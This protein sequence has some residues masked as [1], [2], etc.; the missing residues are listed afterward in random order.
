MGNSTQRRGLPGC[1]VT[2]FLLAAL[3]VAGLG[4]AGTPRGPQPAAYRYFTEPD[5][6]DGW[7]R[8]IRGWQLREPGS[9]ASPGSSSTAAIRGANEVAAGPATEPPSGTDL[10]AKYASVR[11]ARR[12]Q[13]AREL[14]SWIQSQAR[15]HYIEDGPDDHWATLD[16][17]LRGNGD[18]CDG[19]E[20]LTFHLLHDLGF[21]GEEVYRAV[22]YRRSDGQHH[23]VTLWFE[24]RDDPW[25]IDPTSAMTSGMPRMSDV[26]EWVPIKVFSEDR[27]FTV[28][29][30]ALAIR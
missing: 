1:R 12:R 30:N 24:D 20:L 29:S 13:L 10:S 5:S 16:E 14:A 8:K 6:G 15:E 19:L 4:C 11:S 3:V 26:P 22:V 25:V 27:D 18:D 23:M 7:S 9:H 28:R 17:T 2:A 21:R